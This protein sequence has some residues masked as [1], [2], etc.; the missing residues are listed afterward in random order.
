LNGPFDDGEFDVADLQQ[1]LFSVLPRRMPLLFIRESQISSTSLSG[2]AYLARR[3]PEPVGEVA[4]EHQG[5]VV[6]EQ[7]LEFVER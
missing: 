2:A 4:V 1:L 6:E 7:P 3:H 5:H